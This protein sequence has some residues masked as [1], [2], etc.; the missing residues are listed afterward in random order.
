MQGKGEPAEVLGCLEA[1]SLPHSPFPP[2]MP[3]QEPL[4][5]RP[6]GVALQGLVA[7][8]GGEGSQ[9]V[10]EG[11]EDL[12]TRGEVG[13][14]HHNPERVEFE[15]GD[16]VSYERCLRDERLRRQWQVAFSYAPLASYNHWRMENGLGDDAFLFLRNIINGEPRVSQ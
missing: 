4:H 6:A 3:T 13:D 8:A 11:A 5:P 16:A 14:V 2:P 15:E 7:I 1:G 10:E 12:G 9:L